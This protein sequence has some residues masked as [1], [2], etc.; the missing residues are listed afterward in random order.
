MWISNGENGTTAASPDKE[1]ES[2]GKKLAERI[3]EFSK[4]EP[5]YIRHPEDAA[6]LLKIWARYGSRN[7]TNKYLADSLKSRPENAVSLLKCFI[8]PN[9][10]AES[11]N[12]GAFTVNNY[13]ALAEVVDADKVYAALTRSSKYKH[14][15]TKET[16]RVVPADSNII[17]QFMRLHLQQK[18]TG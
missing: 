1:R 18:N 16:D 13:Q 14:D 6:L 10:S 3:R 11:A 8:V 17:S 15:I 7:E 2:L 9:G 5:L 12:A 4:K